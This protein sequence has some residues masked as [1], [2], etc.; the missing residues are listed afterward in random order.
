ME[1]RLNTRVLVCLPFI[2]K[3]QDFSRV[4]LLWRTRLSDTLLHI[5]LIH[6]HSYVYLSLVSASFTSCKD[7]AGGFWLC[8]WFNYFHSKETCHLLS[9]NKWKQ[10]P[11]IVSLMLCL[12]LPQSE[13]L[14][15]Y[16]LLYMKL[17]VA[18]V[19]DVL[20]EHQ[21]S[22]RESQCYS[23]LKEGNFLSLGFLG[24]FFGFPPPFLILAAAE[25][26]DVGKIKACQ[27]VS[28]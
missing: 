28:L 1:H 27:C 2:T 4:V 7:S 10:L 25:L 19:S 5:L 9:S 22:R 24:G 8:Q 15:Y 6:I 26:R 12:F 3:H 14:Y 17:F 23:Q 13:N 18:V 16:F 20:C 21:S 11:D